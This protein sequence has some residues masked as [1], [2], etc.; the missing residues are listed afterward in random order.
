MF[1]LINNIFLRLTKPKKKTAPV[2]T[3]LLYN[4]YESESDVSLRKLI[5]NGNGVVDQKKLEA[6]QSFHEF[7]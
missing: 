3:T 7:L 4:S 2:L 1:E 6:S 5:Q